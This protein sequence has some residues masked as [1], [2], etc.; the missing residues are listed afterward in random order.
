MSPR[1]M[2]CPCLK[3]NW[4]EHELMERYKE[5]DESWRQ[6]MANLTI[7]LTIFLDLAYK[8]NLKQEVP[9]THSIWKWL[10]DA[11]ATLQDCFASPDW[12][13]FQNSSN[14]IE[15]YSTSV[16]GFINMCID[17]VIPTVTVCTFPNQKPW[18]YRQH[19]HRAKG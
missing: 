7:I 19:L 13:T 12:N 10:D 3:S 14:A 15:E 4:I 18:M 6:D 2:N 5:L 16:T 17:D 11:D 8:L 1:E 9:V